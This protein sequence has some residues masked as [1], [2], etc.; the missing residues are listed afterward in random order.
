VTT[1]AEQAKA[2]GIARSLARDEAAKE[3]GRAVVEE[4]IASGEPFS[5]DSLREALDE[6]EVPLSMRGGLMNALPR[7]EDVVVIGEVKSQH[8]ETH[9][10]RVYV[11]VGAHAIQQARA[12]R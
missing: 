11:Y 9:A 1:T 4:A 12:D 2:D 7:R 10:K 8:R 3:R 5:A 6:A